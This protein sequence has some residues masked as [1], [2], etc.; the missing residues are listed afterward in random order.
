MADGQEGHTRIG[1][2]VG[3]TLIAVETVAL[4]GLVSLV[5]G[6]GCNES[7]SCPIDQ[8]VT[9]LSGRGLRL[10]LGWWIVQA[11]LVAA[12]SRRTRES[13]EGRWLAMGAMAA[14]VLALVGPFAVGALA[15]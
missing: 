10:M 15:N 5:V 11:A 8:N 12:G 4:F 13:G 3:A 7:G 14:N 2:T 6:L 9:F 1:L